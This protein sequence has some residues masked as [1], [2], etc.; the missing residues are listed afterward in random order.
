[1]KGAITDPCANTSSPPRRKTRIII[2]RS[3]IFLVVLAKSNNSLK[4]SKLYTPNN[5]IY[6]KFMDNYNFFYF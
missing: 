4:N 2:G 5:I 1:M 6:I 3:H